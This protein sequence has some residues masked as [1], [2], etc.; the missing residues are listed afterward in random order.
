[1]WLRTWMILW[2][3]FKQISRDPRMLGIT[4]GLPIVML[5]IFGYAINFDVKHVRLAIYDQDR[6]ADSRALTE[7]FFRSD[8]FDRVADLTAD[9]EVR[10]TLDGG[11][12]K[13]VL[14]IPPTYARDLA[15]GRTAAVQ[16]LIDGSDS[17]S[18]STAIGYANALL[19]QQSLRI[20]RG[21]LTR[22]G[23]RASGTALP[24][25]LRLRY[26]YN[27]ELKSTTFTIPGLIAVIL[28]MLAT[29]LTS[30]TVARERERGTFEQLAVSPIR[31]IEL[32]VG[33]LA[34][35]VI[36]AFFD[37]I[38]VVLAAILL[39][40]IPF[41]GSYPL[42]LLESVLFLTAGMGLGLFISTVAPSQQIAM[43]IS[44]LSTQLP[45]ILLSGFVFPVRSMPGVMQA[46]SNIFPATHFIFALRTIFLKGGGMA[47]IWPQTLF[48][49]CF[50]A[51]MLVGSATRFRKKL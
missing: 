6:S 15:A 31:P 36:I 33:K 28:M 18:A 17:T 27:P 40:D 34:P 42:L 13:A 30:A 50:A 3:E 2:K 22:A 37:V 38:F 43:M 32:M 44:L 23:V 46:L 24:I 7:A 14:I 5:L 51:V 41:R 10:P 16:L 12:A 39:F 48:L 8:Y 45:S 1:M 47:E 49:F 4:I 25:D 19:A 11:V 35:Y 20:T 26:W 29:L 21:A 9:R